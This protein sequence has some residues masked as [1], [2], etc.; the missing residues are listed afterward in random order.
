MK[1]ISSMNIME[2]EILN[3]SFQSITKGKTKRN[4]EVTIQTN[5]QKLHA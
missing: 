5:F 3:E 1:S 4:E 2:D